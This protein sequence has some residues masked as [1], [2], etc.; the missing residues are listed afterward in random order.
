MMDLAGLRQA[1]DTMGTAL[2]NNNN[3][4][5]WNFA[6]ALQKSSAGDG[7]CR[8]H[9]WWWWRRAHFLDAIVLLG[10]GLAC[11]GLFGESPGRPQPR[12]SRRPP[13]WA[14]VGAIY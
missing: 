11:R 13:I 12:R 3:Y 10:L 4:N 8:C 14:G 6:G 5:R 1:N 7:G 2:A 9:R